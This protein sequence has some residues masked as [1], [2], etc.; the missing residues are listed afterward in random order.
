MPVESS[1]TLEELL[2]G[3]LGEKLISFS[4]EEMHFLEAN[5]E[6]VV[7]K[8]LPLVAEEITHL[9]KGN[10]PNSAASLYWGLAIL[11]SLKEARAFEW[12][13]KLCR[14]E[15]EGIDEFLGN[16]FLTETLPY[17]L[18]AT[19][20][21]RWEEL[22]AEIE[23]PSLDEFIRT[24]CIEALIILVVH[25]EVEREEIIGYFQEI[26]HAI[27][28]HDLD[29]EPLATHLVNACLDLWPGECI[30]EIRELFGLRLIDTSLFEMDDVLISF[31]KGKEICLEK[32]AERV[33]GHHF[34]HPLAKDSL[35]QEQLEPHDLAKR[36]HETD[37]A[38]RFV[39][40]LLEASL[41][42]GSLADRVFE[43][44]R[45]LFEPYTNF[46]GLPEEEQM[47]V[48]ELLS[49]TLSS[50]EQA[51]AITR[52]L[53]D[54]YSECPLLYSHLYLIYC[55]LHW[56]REAIQL[57]KELVEK[58]PDYLFGLVEYARYFLRRGEPEKIPEIFRGAV[59]LEEFYP[60]REKFHTAEWLAFAHVLALYYIEVGDYKLAK[61]Y[62]ELL[63]RIDPECEEVLD[64]RETLQMRAFFK[65]LQQ[66][67]FSS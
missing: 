16:A 12:I 25:Q 60:M 22:K 1:L 39:Q 65:A 53:I 26:F 59:T 54:K 50:P 43:E 10:Q 42:G 51:L 4:A 52:E 34:L 17:V 31:A 9:L 5:R 47:R 13:K 63:E 7:E 67:L 18:A 46:E 6:A 21:G 36:S 58:F 37:Q 64:A 14:V 2:E 27:L 49:M 32:L 56:K 40:S 11:S 62:L 28:Y 55:E 44:E 57:A 38:Y 20:E 15:V 30:E 3:I 33:F 61:N 66:P 29:D 35:Q 41:V 24:A 45:V 19:C 8:L 48:K 23:D